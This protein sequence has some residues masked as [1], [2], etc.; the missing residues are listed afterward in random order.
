MGVSKVVDFDAASPADGNVPVDRVDDFP[1]K[2]TAAHKKDIADLL[3][4]KLGARKCELCDNE[5]WSIADTLMSPVVLAIGEARG[6][7]TRE[8]LLYPMVMITCAN[9]GNSKHL[10]VD[11]LGFALLE[12]EGEGPLST[13]PG[14]GSD[15]QPL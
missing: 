4:A 1:G 9:C 11:R 3:F 15:D 5:R 8:D 2:L 14:E 6:N 10:S 12:Q 13:G 7:I